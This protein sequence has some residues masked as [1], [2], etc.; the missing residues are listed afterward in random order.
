MF[1]PAKAQD[2]KHQIAWGAPDPLVQ[3][4]NYLTPDWVLEPKLDD[5]RMLVQ[6]GTTANRMNSGRTSLGNVP[7]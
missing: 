4:K 5:V 1:T 6:L 2:L 3:I 7:K